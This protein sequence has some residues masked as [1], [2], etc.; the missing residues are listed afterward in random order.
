[1]HVPKGPPSDIATLMQ[2]AQRLA[3][4]SLGELAQLANIAVPA[5]FRRHKGWSGQLIE[6]WLGAEAG[7]KPEQD[8]AHLGIELKTLPLSH[9]LLPLE[10]TYVCYAHLTGNQGISWETSNL[11]N[12]LRTVLWVPIQGERAIA[13]CDRVVGTAILWQPSTQQLAVLQQDWEE[14]MDMICLGKVEQIDAKIGQALQL[15]PKAA[16]GKALTAAIGEDGQAIMTR[17]RGFYLRKSF[18]QQILC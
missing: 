17:P 15:R 9:Q 16:N 13:P 14:I 6:R 8:F 4:L 7:S 11:Y 12:K 2:R 10:T 1:M 3:G 18:T 5:D